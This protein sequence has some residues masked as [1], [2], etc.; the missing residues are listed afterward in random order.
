MLELFPFVI[1]NGFLYRVHAYA[2]IHAVHTRHYTGRPT[3]AIAFD[4]AI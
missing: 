1:L 3:P 4:R 2:M